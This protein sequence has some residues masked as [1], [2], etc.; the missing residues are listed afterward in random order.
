MWLSLWLTVVSPITTHSW[1]LT[2][3]WGHLP[4]ICGTYFCKVYIKLSIE[5]K[6]NNI[7]IGLTGF[8]SGGGG[9]IPPSAHSCPPPLVT[10]IVKFCAFG[11]SYASPP[12]PNY[13]LPFPPP[14]GPNP[15]RNN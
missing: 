4:M 6:D 3:E 5:Q 2:E 7:S 13:I 12:P 15:K 1:V 8:L 14:L 11:E 10:D 9:S